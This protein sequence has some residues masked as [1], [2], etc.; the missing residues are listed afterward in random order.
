[1]IQGSER[2][3]YFV[4]LLTH[5]LSYSPKKNYQLTFY[6]M[7]LPK[8]R[9]LKNIAANGGINIIAA[10]ATIE[11][12][13]I[14]QPI[15]FP[16]LKGLY[17]WRIPLVNKENSNLFLPKLSSEAFKKLTVGQLHSWSDTKVLESNDIHV[18]KGSHY[19]GLFQMLEANRFDYFPRSIL[20]A[21]AELDRNK[22]L[23]I[24]ID[25]NILLHYP[26]AYLFYVNKSNKI[27]AEDVTY[28][29]EQALKD[30]SFDRIFKR[31]YGEMVNGTIKENR[32]VYH[33]K[34]PFLPK[35]I[36]LHRK[37]LWLDLST[38]KDVNL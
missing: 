23:N 28:G 16:I 25:T 38:D 5:A 34:N 32:S 10:G 26:T 21:Q 8:P 29:L 13:K 15:W 11:R 3:N 20:E 1:V 22:N 9:V 31:Y 36:P 4:E 6:N 35:K 33:L 18:E 14:L 30:G 17:G 27:L 12:E 24:T 37:I 19:Q 2:N 7:R